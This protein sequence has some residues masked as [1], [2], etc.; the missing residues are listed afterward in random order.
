MCGLLLSVAS[1]CESTGAEGLRLEAIAFPDETPILSAWRIRSADPD[2]G[3]ISGA[4]LA[5]GGREITLVSDRG[6]AFRLLLRRDAGEALKGAELVGKSA[7]SGIEGPLS[8]RR[9]RDA[10]ELAAYRGGHLVAFEHFH[11]L[12]WHR[13][14]LDR[15]PVS[16]PLPKQAVTL[17]ENS[18]IEAMTVLADGRIVLIA[19]EVG[20]DG[21]TSWIGDG[22]GAWR[23]STYVPAPSY[24]PTGAAALPDGS[25]VVLERHFTLFGGFAALLARAWPNPDGVWRREELMRLP[26]PALGENFEAVTVWRDRTGRM[27]ALLASDDNFSLLQSTLFVEVALP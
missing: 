16:V 23:A 18:G 1:G 19:E 20:P 14:G 24:R 27:R 22:Q 17:P 10:E 9:D 13:D 12:R 3:G 6:H 4:A 26:G 8:R 21:A 2:F 5:P 25:I 15:P 11:R 7:L